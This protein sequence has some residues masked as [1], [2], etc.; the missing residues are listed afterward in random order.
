MST[1]DPYW[2]GPVDGE[3]SRKSD[4]FKAHLRD[5]TPQRNSKRKGAADPFD[6]SFRV[7]RLPPRRKR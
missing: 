5:N 3:D 6:P 1:H 4:E 2:D 7:T